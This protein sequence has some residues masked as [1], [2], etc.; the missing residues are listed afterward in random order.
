MKLI[1]NPQ[2][3]SQLSAQWRR[4]GWTVGFVPTMGALHEGHR[5]LIQRARRENDRIIVSIFVNPLQFGPSE[6]YNRYPRPFYQDRRLCEATWVDAL[7]RPS[8]EDM[9]PQGFG[10]TV[11][12]QGLGDRLDGEFRPGHFK[13]V[14]TVVLKLLEHAGPDKA[15]FG[16]KDYQQLTIIQKMVHDLS[17]GV[18]VI[19]CPTVR[20]RD[21]LA[22]S[23]RNAYLSPA[24]R[25]QAPRLYEGLAAGVDAAKRAKAKPQ[26]VLRAAKRAI[27][28]IAKVSI[29]YVRLVDASTLEDAERLKGKLRLLAAVRVGRT[30]LIDNVAV[31][32]QD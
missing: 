10:T 28:K 7:Y 26:D 8:P 25:A 18:Q 29:D 4:R 12:V 1:R 14:T 23:S 22:L 20:E 11:E 17:L 16:E 6:D 30:R 2:E 13:G 9:Y 31:I 19:P 5:S 32:C 24:E 21:G 27:Q 15:Y 3:L